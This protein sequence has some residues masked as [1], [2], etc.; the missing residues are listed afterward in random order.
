MLT[1]LAP[2][3][4]LSTTGAITLARVVMDSHLISCVSGPL[5]LNA[6]QMT[7]SSS[8]VSGGD[9]TIGP[10]SSPAGS[11]TMQS[12]LSTLTVQSPILSASFN[13]TGSNNQLT[14]N[15]SP[16]V[17]SVLFV[18]SMVLTSSFQYDGVGTSM[19]CSQCT[20]RGPN[21]KINPSSLGTFVVGVS[22]YFLSPSSLHTPLPNPL[23]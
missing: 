14:A 7:A 3:C 9:L 15:L 18:S 5:T 19:N 8:I 21:D 12:S 1:A 4:V 2:G 22:R 16:S 6:L 20:F 11:I 23:F 10:A 13:L 17:D